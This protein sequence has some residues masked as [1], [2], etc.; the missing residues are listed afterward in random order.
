MSDIDTEELKSFAPIIPYIRTYYSNKLAIDE[1]RSTNKIMYAKCL[2]HEEN[3]A[4]LVFFC[5][6]T[7]K[8]FGCGEHGDVITFVQRVENVTFQEA[9]QIVGNNVGYEVILTPPNPAHEAYKD[10]LDNYTR[11]YWSNLQQD[12]NALSYLVCE[13]G[14]DK[15]MIDLF[16]IGFTD[17]E[18]YKYRTD[19]G[20]ISSKIVFPILEHKRHNPKCVGMA[21]RGLTDEKP[22]YINDQNQDGRDG[23]DPNLSGVFIKGNL[24]YG[25]PYAYNDIANSGYLILVE[26]Y[27]DVIS[28]HQSGIKN[29]VGA[30]GTSITDNQIKE[31][32]KVTRNVVLFLDGDKAGTNAMLKV[33]KSLY[34]AGLQ[35][36]ICTLDNNI[37]PAD[38]CKSLSFDFNQISTVIKRKTKPAIEIVINKATERYE[39]IAITERTKAL[40]EAM[41]IIDV[42][43]DAAIKDLYKSQLYKK[44]DI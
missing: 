31:I 23:Q 16:R 4:S 6:G 29:V 10:T 20:N 12:G 39:T 24:L 32:A 38:L 15:S 34:E 42:I 30:M 27:M 33:V 21:Y 14:I 35:V 37:D 8:C 40:N 26:G 18:E 36:A 43:P 41:P 5:N 3:T 25:L 13:R 9:C 17:K 19:I 44:L 28:L 22:K 1:K 11:R 7:Y 2:W